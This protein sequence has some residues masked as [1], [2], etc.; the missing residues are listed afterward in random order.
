[1]WSTQMTKLILLKIQRIALNT[2]LVVMNSSNAEWPETN[3]GL[4]FSVSLTSRD[5]DLTWPLGYPIYKMVIDDGS[6]P[7]NSKL[8]LAAR[9]RKKAKTS[10]YLISTSADDLRKDS[11][12]Y[13]AKVPPDR[14]SIPGSHTDGWADITERFRCEVMWWEHVL[15]RMIMERDQNKA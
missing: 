5:L 13:V 8:V 15:F 10:S 7:E 1:M 2:P 9:K 12:S 11:P 6:S 3:A 14:P 4:M